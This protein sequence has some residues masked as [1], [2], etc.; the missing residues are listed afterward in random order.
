MHSKPH[1]MQ[2]Q[3]V[4]RRTLSSAQRDCNE[5]DAVHW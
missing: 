4:V 3:W 5:N 1:P 2:E